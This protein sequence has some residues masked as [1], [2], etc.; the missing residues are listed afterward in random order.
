MPEHILKL[1]TLLFFLSVLF[2]DIYLLISIEN[3]TSAR[4]VGGINYDF[5]RE[6]PLIVEGF[7][8]LWYIPSRH[9]VVGESASWVLN[10]VLLQSVFEVQ[11]I[12]PYLRGR[13]SSQRWLAVGQLL[14]RLEDGYLLSCCQ[15]K[16]P[17]IWLV[18]IKN[19]AVQGWNSPKSGPRVYQLSQSPWVTAV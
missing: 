4:T 7:G 16:F 5:Y 18:S 12:S 2:L 19:S 14:I 11:K 17:V 8:T 10:I 6:W 1:F 13:R 3:G 9:I 15:K